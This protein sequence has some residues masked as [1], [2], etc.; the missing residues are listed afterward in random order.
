MAK[1]KVLYI[2]D[3]PLNLS[4][5]KASFRRDYEIFTAKSAEE[6][7]AIL[8]NHP[9]EV[10]LSD[11]KMPGKTGVDFFEV[12]AKSHPTPMRILITAYSDINAIIDAINKGNVYRYITKPW[13]NYELKLTIENAHQIYA[14]KE[15]N[16]NLN[17]K[18]KKVFSESTDPIILLNDEFKIIDFN[19]ATVNL[20]GVDN[21]KLTSFDS[22]FNNKSE[23]QK[24]TTIINEK[25]T[26]KDYECQVL[27][28]SGKKKVCLISGNII[29][30]NYDELINYQLLIKDITERSKSNQLLLERTI[31]TQEQERE[32]ISRDLHDGLGQYLVAIKLHLASLSSSFDQKKNI[33]DEL[34]IVHSIM[35]NAITELRRICF[36]ALPIVLQEYGL[37]K[38]IKQL[39]FNVSNKDFIINF[40]YSE[41]SPNPTKSLETSIFRIIQEFIN[42]SIKHSGATEVNIEL[43]T[44]QENTLLSIKDNGVGFNIDKMKYHSGHGLK[45]IQNRIKSY[46]GNMSMNSVINKGTELNIKFPP[47]ID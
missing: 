13:D 32:R 44:A 17:L 37:I 20:I 14:L 43:K 31:E 22:F 33:K 21:L 12:I 1:I 28:S 35:G 39:Q 23:A 26:L 5:F 7:M 30:N 42:N 36:N 8:K 24:I 47:H 15:Q 40:N 6:G 11:Q 9:I 38:A 16:K 46:K 45:N 10:I 27:T 41:Y 19:P 18:Y 34:N 4:A 3:E 25:S 2:D 29:S